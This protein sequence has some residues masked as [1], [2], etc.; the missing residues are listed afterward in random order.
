[1]LARY[2]SWLWKV[3]ATK[4]TY[5]EPLRVSTLLKE[6]RLQLNRRAPSLTLQRLEKLLG[7]L[8]GEGIIRRWRY[9]SWSL[10]TAPARGWAEGWLHALVTIE[11]PDSVV[12]HYLGN[13]RGALPDGKPAPLPDR[14]RAT[15]ERL[16][17]TQ[18]RAAEAAGVSQQAYSRAERGKGVS[19]TNRGELEAWLATH[20]PAPGSE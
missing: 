6:S 10:D 19:A 15:R 5:S 3:R 17:L 18:E 13:L 7:T 14:L 20:S 4:G 12:S 11:P 1:M 8:Q 16:E 9:T 2:L